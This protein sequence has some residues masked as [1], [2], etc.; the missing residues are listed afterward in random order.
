[1]KKLISLILSI[2]I[3]GAALASCDLIRKYEPPVKQETQESGE[4]PGNADDGA[5]TADPSDTADENTGS[6]DDAVRLTKDEALALLNDAFTDE[7]KESVTVDPDADMIGQSNG[8][9]Y[10]IFNAVKE[11]E[12]EDGETVSE[13]VIY[14]VS[15]NAA[16]YESLEEDNATVSKAAK[17]FTDKY[18][19]ADE[20]GNAYRIEYV[21]LIMNSGAYCYNFEAYTGEGDGA[22]LVKAF[23]VSLDGHS[24]GEMTE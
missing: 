17:L 18:G 13:D 6:D 22:V 4:D 9:E 24:Y 16:I 8:T 1:M 2:C 20:N 11:T 23:L 21:G 3:I 10:Y 19:L 15:T 14:Y 12:D 7:E 5:N